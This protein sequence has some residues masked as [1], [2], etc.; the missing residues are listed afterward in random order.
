MCSLCFSL[1]FFPSF[2]SSLLPSLPLRYMRVCLWEYVYA[3]VH[4]ACMEVRVSVLVFHLLS[5]FFL[6]FYFIF[7]P[8]FLFYGGY[9]W[10]FVCFFPPTVY[11]GLAVLQASRGSPCLCL[12]SPNRSATVTDTSATHP[13]FTRLW[14]YEL[15]S[16]RLCKKCFSPMEP[17][18]PS[19]LLAVP[20]I[21]QLGIVLYWKIVLLLQVFFVLLCMPGNSWLDAR[22]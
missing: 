4:G 14:G 17:S 9:L 7:P 2:P 8:S 20:T 16:S 19:P 12:S 3:T 11:A 10:I 18:S 6:K 5:F 1:S 15:G 22:L 13:A 21:C